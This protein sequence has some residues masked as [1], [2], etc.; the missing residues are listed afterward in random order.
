M[1]ANRQA[2]SV[3]RNIIKEICLECST[4]GQSV[5]ETLAAFMVK[6]AV[7]HPDNDFNVERTLLK[8][9]VQKLIKTC[10]SQLMDSS[11]PS[12]DTIKMQVYFGMNYSTRAEFL[13]EH[14][15]VLDTRLL[16]IMREI[17]DTR[18]RN[19]EEL[20]GLYRKIV[21]YV[22]LRSGLGSPTDI[23][24]VR[25][26]TAAL[27]SV[28][29]QMELGSFMALDKGEKEVQLKELTS[30]VTGIRL[31]NREC[32]KGGQGIDDLPSILRDAVQV[33]TQVAESE[34][35]KSLQIS[36]ESTAALLHIMETS[37]HPYSHMVGT[38]KKCLVNSRQHESIIQALKQ[39]IVQCAKQLEL[40]EQDFQAKMA[41]L[42][43]TVQ[44]KTAVPTSQVY[45][46]F[47][48]LSQLWCKFQDEVNAADTLNTPEFRS[49][50]S[51][52]A[53]LTDEQ[54]KKD[55]SEH[56]VDPDKHRRAEFLFPENTRDFEKIPLEMKGYC[57]YSLSA[58]D[59]LLLPA[60]SSIGVL[61]YKG[62]YYAF[63]NKA[64][65]DGFAENPESHLAKAVECSKRSPELIYLLDMHTHFSGATPGKGGM[66]DDLIKSPV[67]KSDIGTQTDT[68]LMESNLVK[69]YEWNEWEL[70][71]KAIKLAN[72]RQRITHSVQTELSH[73]TRENSTQVYLPKDSDTQTQRKQGSSVP[74]PSTYMA[75]LRGTAEAGRAHKVDLTLSIHT[76][77]NIRS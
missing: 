43:A 12:L 45:P 51:S 9:D 48:A 38:I 37:L 63:S 47:T 32:G 1:T 36:F 15:H 25:E 39:D 53:V 19:R 72:L 4:H 69:S 62:R 46:L 14:H 41:A 57:I 8:D 61:H 21:S 44:S 74:N 7:L 65:A 30:I 55:S 56:R 10:V 49:L 75:G 24:V 40:T 2:E 58:Y 13:Q 18:A 54:R 77:N 76:H 23:A 66:K 52:T 31:F 35:S 33:T 11:S 50:V 71:R 6:A 64:A 17:S 67:I 70:R 73:Y 27:Q 5:S 29:P 42:K 60:N 3:I 26:A 34:L 28:F 16:P 59:G 20:D 68:H 22:L